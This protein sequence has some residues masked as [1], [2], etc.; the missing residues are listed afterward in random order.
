PGLLSLKRRLGKYRVLN[1]FGVL[2]PIADYKGKLPLNDD[3]LLEWAILD[4][5]D[6]LSA[7][8]DQPQPIEEVRAW[9]KKSGLSEVE[10]RYGGNGI[11]GRGIKK[12]R[13][14]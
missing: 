6:A 10:V 12:A 1:K 9:F 5:F 7:R 8:Y 3:Q 2:I 14:A 4:T 11:I 13:A